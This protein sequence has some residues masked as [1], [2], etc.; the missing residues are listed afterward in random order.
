M[1]KY[2]VANGNPYAVRIDNPNQLG[3]RTATIFRDAEPIKSF[4]DKNESTLARMCRSFVQETFGDITYEGTITVDD[5]TL[6]FIAQKREE[7]AK[8]IA[9]VEEKLLERIKKDFKRFF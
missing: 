2:Y 4:N 6:K 8:G 3:I 1:I 7:E 5:W 9:D